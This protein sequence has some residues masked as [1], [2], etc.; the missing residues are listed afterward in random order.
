M[1]FEKENLENKHVDYKMLVREYRDGIL[2]FQLMDEKVWSKS[3]EDTVGLSNFF[4]QHRD[5]YKWDTR[6]EATILS[7]A[8]PETL[9]KARQLMATGRYELRKNIPAP[10]IFSA[11]K[12][13]ITARAKNQLDELAARLAA[14]TSLTAVI[15]GRL[16]AKEAT[17]RNNLAQQR[18]TQVLNYLVNKGIVPE[19]LRIAE[20]K[21]AANLRSAIITLYSTDLR[22]L[23]QNLNESNPLALQASRRRFQKGEN[24]V[25]DGVN[26]QEGSQTFE[27]DGR[28]YFIRIDKVLPP[29]YKNLD[30]TRGVATSDYQAYLE[31]EWLNQLRQRYPVVV[32]QAELNKL[33]KKQ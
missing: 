5:N 24:K 7:A 17:P 18:A 15:T 22:I 2:L 11:G 26:W 20:T 25:L 10:V 1:N 4:Q 9:V 16:D 27:K 29:A 33:I 31:K 19:R 12:A 30:E 28:S 3:M 8:N 14:D 13:V 21:T 6:A 32:N 23:E